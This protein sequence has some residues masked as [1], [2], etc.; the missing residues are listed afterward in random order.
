[1]ITFLIF[2]TYNVLL[3]VHT[4][5]LPWQSSFEISELSLQRKLLLSKIHHI[6]TSCYMTKPLFA[7]KPLCWQKFLSLTFFLR[8]MSKGFRVLKPG[9]SVSVSVYQKKN[10]NY[11]E[12]CCRCCFYI[13]VQMVM[14]LNRKTYLS[15]IPFIFSLSFSKEIF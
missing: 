12:S 8:S 4:H 1:M 3:E 6:Y 10:W 11:H 2:I 14:K 5:K 15:D 13:C 7:Q 9:N